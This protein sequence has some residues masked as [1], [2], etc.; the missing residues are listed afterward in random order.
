M[1]AP[2]PGAPHSCGFRQPASCRSRTRRKS[3]APQFPPGA[4][5]SCGFKQPA[6]CRSRTRRKSLAPQFPPGAPH[7]CG[8]R[9][10][11]SCR[12]R[13]RRKSL[14][15]QFPPGAPHSCGFRQPASC[16]SRTCRKSLAPQFPP[17]APRSHKCRQ[18]ASI[19]PS[20]PQKCRAPRSTFHTAVNSIDAYRRT[21]AH[22]RAVRSHGLRCAN[23]QVQPRRRIESAPAPGFVSLYDAHRILG[24]SVRQLANLCDGGR[25]RTA[26]KGPGKTCRWTVA[27]AEVL[28]KLNRKNGA[29]A[30]AQPCIHH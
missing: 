16:R 11:T 14:A 7:S 2:L 18:P 21:A 9:Q 26:R 23:A 8:F 6:S 30:V 22:A 4:P 25:F 5:H 13:T 28:E 1:A 20:K 10:P 3:L 12:S 27:L 15:P 24:L 17:G 19:R 29:W